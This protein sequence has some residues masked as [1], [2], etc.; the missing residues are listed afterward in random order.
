MT[1]HYRRRIGVELGASILAAALLAVL[2]STGQWYAIA[3]VG[4]GLLS[5]LILLRFPRLHWVMFFAILPVYFRQ[6]DVEV[7][8]FDILMAAYLAT[9]LVVWLVWVLT[10][11]R[12]ELL[13][14]RAEVVLWLA[15]VFSLFS[16]VVAI[17]RGGTLLNWA[18]EWALVAMVAYYF[19]FRSTFSS[20][21]QF[22]FYAV[23]LVLLSASL[24]V[25][26]A[27]NF[28]Q[29]VLEALYAYQIRGV[30]G[31]NAVYLIGFFL[32]IALLL[33]RER[34]WERVLWFACASIIAGGIVLTY[35]R[36]VWVG[37][38]VAIVVMLVVL[39]TVQRLRLLVAMGIATVLIGS[40]A[41]L[42]FGNVV[43]VVGRVI[44]H[45]FLSVK[46]A[47]KETSVR[48]RRDELR[49]V[50]SLL[51][52]PDIAAAGI[53]P[54]G[55]YVYYDSAL[56]KPVRTHFLHNGMVGL[57]VKFGI[58][59]GLTFYLFHLLMLAKSIRCYVRSR[60]TPLEPYV[61]SFTLTLI[62]TTVMD[63]TTNAFFLRSGCLFLAMLYAGVVIAERLLG[64]ENGSPSGVVSGHVH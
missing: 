41:Q 18:R 39:P 2:A 27:F 36:T 31:V 23:L 16:A 7:S 53:G 60:R 43:D 33:Y 10:L 44:V 21:R 46:T 19:V 4:A 3:G 9:L 49:R 42:V 50:L 63:W 12:S 48:E 54:G 13:W 28:R 11:R 61:L 35:T 56:G 15:L 64:Q 14:E 47:T 17:V 20:P 32:S 6:S 5:A 26:A 58:P 57:M 37:S 40:V 38:I 59:L 34:W 51:Q 55:K 25:V 8:A 30:K 24:A 29:Q 62:G 45:R 1:Q 52:R 22:R